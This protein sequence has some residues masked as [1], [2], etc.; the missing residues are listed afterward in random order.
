MQQIPF[1]THQSDYAW[2]QY[3]GSKTYPS[4]FQKTTFNVF[5][6][7]FQIARIAGFV[8]PIYLQPINEHISV[9]HCK[10]PLSQ[11]KYAPLLAD[12]TVVIEI[13]PF[14]CFVSFL[15][16]SENINIVFDNMLVIPWSKLWSKYTGNSPVIIGDA[17]KCK[18]WIQF[19]SFAWLKSPCGQ[20][21]HFTWTQSTYPIQ[22]GRP[23]SLYLF[24]SVSNTYSSLGK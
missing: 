1:C 3:W 14:H 9:G 19:F 12:V 21:D 16:N 15:T 5:P 10:Y 2:S 17:F 13:F 24:I 23:T 6:H 22:P 4:E 8:M 7:T 11:I 18:G 20:F